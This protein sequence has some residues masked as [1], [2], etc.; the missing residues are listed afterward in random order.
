[1]LDFIE[2]GSNSDPSLKTIQ[3]ETVKL[4][5]HDVGE[6]PL[7]VLLHGFPDTAYT[8]KDTQTI[9]KKRRLSQCC[10]LFTWIFPFRNPT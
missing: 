10:T 5:Y 9:L 1:M 3:L 8:W 2:N 7:V 4:A 6:G